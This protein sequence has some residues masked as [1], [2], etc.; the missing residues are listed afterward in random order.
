VVLQR[1]NA[2]LAS[3]YTLQKSADWQLHLRN[4]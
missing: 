4:I 3:R 2:V 1:G